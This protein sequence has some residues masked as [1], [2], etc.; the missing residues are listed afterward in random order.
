LLAGVQEQLAN[1]GKQLLTRRVHDKP[2]FRF[3]DH[4][5]LFPWLPWPDRK[6]FFDA[7]THFPDLEKQFD[8]TRS[9]A[10]Q[11]KD[12]LGV[13]L[14]VIRV[15]PKE[16]QTIDVEKSGAIATSPRMPQNWVLS[17]QHLS[18]FLYRLKREAFFRQPVCDERFSLAL[19]R[20]SA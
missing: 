20:F 10:G 7:V 1:N 9:L 14:G 15:V 17:W 18:L 19:W 5:S 11:R 16:V 13:S 3:E 8:L 12:G 4:A 6:I 2:V